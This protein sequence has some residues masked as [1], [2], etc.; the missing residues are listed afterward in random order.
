VL[1][2]RNYCGK[3]AI[4]ASGASTPS[5]RR[6]SHATARRQRGELGRLGPLD[7]LDYRTPWL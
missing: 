3:A 5:A 6:L 4:T 7:A 1:T 2:A